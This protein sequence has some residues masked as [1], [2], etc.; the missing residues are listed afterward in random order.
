MPLIVDEMK[1][2]GVFAWGLGEDS[3]GW[4]HLNA[5]NEVYSAWLE[6]HPKSSKDEL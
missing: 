4:S 1:L 5:L 3:E 6:R 2:G